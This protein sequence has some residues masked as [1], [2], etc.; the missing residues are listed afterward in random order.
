MVIMSRV[1]DLAGV[2]LNLLVVLDELL[3]AR[4]TT[5]AA[6]RL[7]RTQS[8][9]SHAL[10]RLRDA[11]GD[12]LFVRAGA[13]LRPTPFAEGLA[14]PLADVLHGAAALLTRSRVAFDPAALE[15]TFAL[16]CT[17]L[18]EIT[19]LPRLVPAL[20]RDAPG[21]DVVTRFLGDDVERAVQGRE[22]DLGIGT[23]L[24]P[25][26]GVVVEPL[27]E[28]PMTILLRRGHPALEGRLTPK[29]Y[30]ALD[31][32]L[33]TPRGLPGSSVDSALEP[34]G[35]ARRVVLRLP[36]F[37]AA[38]LVVAKTDLVVT[39]PES[40]ARE[41]GKRLGLVARPVPVPLPKVAFLV[42]YSATFRDDPGHRFVR[43]RVM[44]AARG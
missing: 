22:V 20:R 30:A 21:V 23:R 34:L 38:A 42:A 6:R 26:A 13:A 33:V 41:L 36:H 27:V 8:A 11:L 10:A 1:H 2:D 7:G 35:L 19:I 17:D 44:A 15:R 9:V 40:L 24:R 3:R 39:V 16:S 29:R 25:L 37:A 18:A 4:S 43:E 32:A 31:H 28:E 5:L 14:A 12:P